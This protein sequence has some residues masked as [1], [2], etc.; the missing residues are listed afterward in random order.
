M[1]S[2]KHSQDLASD[3]VNCMHGIQSSGSNT[4]QCYMKRQESAAHNAEL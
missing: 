4:I 1:A 2:C 3:V